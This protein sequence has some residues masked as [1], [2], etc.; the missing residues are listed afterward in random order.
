MSS[1]TR[2]L[3]LNIVLTMYEIDFSPKKNVFT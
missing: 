2:I 3:N 1:V